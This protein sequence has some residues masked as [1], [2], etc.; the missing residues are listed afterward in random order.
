MRERDREDMGISGCRV[1]ACN[2]PRRAAGHVLDIL[3]MLCAS[4]AALCSLSP[5]AC[6]CCAASDES[7][8]AA[9]QFPASLNAEEAEISIEVAGIFQCGRGR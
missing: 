8:A 2:A 1:Y 7:E 3:A 9:E 5:S 4:P 6:P